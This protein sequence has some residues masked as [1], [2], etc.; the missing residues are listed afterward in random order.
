MN[1]MLGWIFD[2]DTRDVVFAICGA[3]AALAMFLVKG[4]RE[5][6]AR[7]AA[8]DRDLRLSRLRGHA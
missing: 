2:G 4:R 1:E 5:R 7:A 6:R 3:S 8:R